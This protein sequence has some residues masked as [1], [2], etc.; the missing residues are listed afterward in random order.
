VNGSLKKNKSEF[1][2]FLFIFG[3]LKR[4]K[5]LK[6]KMHHRL[7]EDLISICGSK[8]VSDEEFVRRGYTRTPSI[9]SG[10]R[11]R[12]LTPGIVVRPGSTEEVSEIMNLANRELVPVV[13]KGGG[14]SVTISPPLHV[15]TSENI[16][17][18]TTRM[19]K[20]IEIDEETMRATAECGII[21]STFSAAVKR[22]GFHLYTTDVPVHMDTLG[23]VLSGFCGGGEPSDMCT[24]G[25][26]NNY[27]LGLKVVLP[28]GDIIQTGG[29]PGTNIFLNKILHREAGTPD[30]TGMFIGDGGIFGVKTEATLT[31]KPFPKTYLVGTYKMGSRENM[32]KAFSKLVAMDPYP[33]TRLIMYDKEWLLFY[34]ISE[35]FDEIAEFKEKIVRDTCISYGGE[36]AGT[37]GLEISKAFS[38]RELGK[39]EATRG[40]LTYF[41]EA[42]VPRWT[43]LEYIDSLETL[44]DRTFQPSE[45]TMRAGFIVPYLRATA[46]AGVLVYFSKDTPNLADRM[47][48]SITGFIGLFAERG[49]FIEANQGEAAIGCAAFWSPSYRS[50]VQSLKNAL[51]PNNILMPGLWGF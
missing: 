48:E 34:V 10:G 43:A 38:A 40:T 50:F 13:P 6:E 22:R 9:S 14:G 19:N 28:K 1:F 12:G 47:S 5:E 31:I 23:G 29:G 15:G 46:I 17:I 25:C 4:M 8:Y 16:L 2:L 45:I 35:Y 21:L 20:I 3:G 32:W 18:D 36:D 49:G 33:Y 7:Y 11:V 24:A 37:A 44:L 27:V 41:G 39:E 30:L 51:D 42:I 26:L